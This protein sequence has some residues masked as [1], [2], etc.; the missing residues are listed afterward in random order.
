MIEELKRKLKQCEDVLNA[1]NVR[2][3][4]LNEMAMT[5]DDTEI[6]DIISDIRVVRERVEVEAKACMIARLNYNQAAFQPLCAI[7]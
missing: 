2:L 1:D 6:E 3:A 7:A 5:A 4:R